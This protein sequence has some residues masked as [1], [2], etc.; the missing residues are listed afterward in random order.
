MKKGEGKNCCNLSDD[1]IDEC[2]IRAV[3]SDD[4]IDEWPSI[5]YTLEDA[6]YLLPLYNTFLPL[7]KDKAICTT[8]LCS[9]NLLLC[10]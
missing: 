5:N 2:S 9:S 4:V 7:N 3:L 10:N 6:L 8:F 1:I